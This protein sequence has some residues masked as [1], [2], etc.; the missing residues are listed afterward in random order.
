MTKL[1]IMK[2]TSYTATPLKY[3]NIEKLNFEPNSLEGKTEKILEELP[4]EPEIFNLEEIPEELKGETVH[5]VKD[6]NTGALLRVVHMFDGKLHGELIVYDQTE[7]VVNRLNYKNGILDGKAEFFI[8]QKPLMQTNFKDGLQEGETIIF[9]L[10]VKIAVCN[11]SK[12]M[13]EGTFTNF[14]TLGNVLRTAIYS[15]NLQNGECTTYYPD[16]TV[17]EKAIYKNGKLDGE[18]LRFYPNGVLREKANYLEG[19]Q[20]GIQENYDTNGKLQSKTEIKNSEV[21]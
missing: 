16:G 7:N 18:V 1:N 15:K 21:V 17:L 19:K 10:G 14:D 11:Y 9:S 12:G 5:E 20:V 8:D 3:E 2:N 13:L 4:S 6:P